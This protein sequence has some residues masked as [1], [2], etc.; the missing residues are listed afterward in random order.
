MSCG[1]NLRATAH[2][3]PDVYN[4]NYHYFRPIVNEHGP[5]NIY[6]YSN[7][8]QATGYYSRSDLLTEQAKLATYFQAAYKPLSWCKIKWD[9]M[10][11]R[12]W[13]QM[14]PVRMT[15]LISAI[16]LEDVLFC[17]IIQNMTR[18]PVRPMVE[19]ISYVCTRTL[20]DNIEEVD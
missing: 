5:R 13:A 6:Q 2:L 10:L 18:L 9:I 14:N 20:D 15:H 8:K 7:S 17:T 4:M 16:K 19:I 11:F 3:L 12:S 1:A